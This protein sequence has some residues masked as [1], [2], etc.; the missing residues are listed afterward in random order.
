M[1]LDAFKKYKQEDQETVGCQKPC[2]ICHVLTDH[3]DLMSNGARCFAC[4]DSY[5]R[6]PSTAEPKKYLDDPK[7]WA[8]R[9]IDKHDAGLPV[10][11]I[12]LEIAKKALAKN[13]EEQF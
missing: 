13:H 9:I 10:S 5:C 11:R 6:Q 1:A 12:S 2:S 8:K 7:G 3:R 4:Y